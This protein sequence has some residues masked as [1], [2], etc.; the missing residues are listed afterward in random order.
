MGQFRPHAQSQ[1]RVV[2]RLFRAPY[3]I[4]WHGLR[5]AQERLNLLGVMWTVIGNDWKWPAERIAKHVLAHSSPGG[6]I[7]LH[8]G[9]TVEPKPDVSAMLTAVRQIVPVLKD[10]GY[11]FEVISD[12]LG[13]TAP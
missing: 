1:C 12:L 5:A 8:D 3:G 2:P 11:R 10:Q 4:R 9:R 13:D 6:I 7:C